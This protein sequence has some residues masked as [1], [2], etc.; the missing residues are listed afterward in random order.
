MIGSEKYLTSVVR[1][2]FSLKEIEV[3]D[4]YP[5]NSTD[6]QSMTSAFCIQIDQ[7]E[8]DVKLS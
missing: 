6:L 2:Q 4:F 5:K 7:E 1:E 8:S 3:T